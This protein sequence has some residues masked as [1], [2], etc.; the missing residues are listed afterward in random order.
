[1]SA[2]APGGGPMDRPAGWPELAPYL[3]AL[4][5][6]ERASFSRYAALGLPDESED[7]EAALLAYAAQNPEAN[8]SGL[9][10][11]TGAQAG[12]A[13]D[14]GLARRL[15]VAALDLADTPEER[16]LAHV[17][18]AQTHFRNRREEADLA[19]FVEHCRAAV[20]LGHAGT[21]CYERLATLYEYRGE[22]EAAMWVCRRA[23]EVLGAEDPD[24]A[25]RFRRRLRRLADK[26]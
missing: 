22:L 24:S 4:S 14:L 2:S 21:F 1:M 26:V 13:G 12:L 16:Q 5:V 6:E 17:C 3:A 23:V 19:G 20:D 9:L 10:A 15:G 25:E 18:L 7:V 8:P 11:T